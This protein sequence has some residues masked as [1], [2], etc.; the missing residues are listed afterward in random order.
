MHKWRWSLRDDCAASSPYSNCVNLPSVLWRC[1]LGGKKSIR[2]VKTEWWGAGVVICLEWGADLLMAQLMLLPLTV[3]CF[4]EIQIG[5]TFLVPT[6]LG[7]P[8]KEPLNGCCFCCQFIDD[9]SANW[10]NW[11]TGY[12]VNSLPAT[13]GSVKYGTGTQRVDWSRPRATKKLN[14]A[15]TQSD[16]TEQ[17]QYA[18]V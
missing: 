3:S 12:P 17:H 2:S 1:L 16:K 9:I 18:T 13:Y 11:P 4:S 15:A 8:G 14:K 7:S 6:H 5:F 10:L